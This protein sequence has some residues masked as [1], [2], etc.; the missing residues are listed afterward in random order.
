[1]AKKPQLS[2]NTNPLVENLETNCENT[3]QNCVPFTDPYNGMASSREL[4]IQIKHKDMTTTCL[5]SIT[6]A[7]L[8]NP[9]ICH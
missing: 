8:T 2:E 9:V 6:G 7:F 4:C 1:M 3:Y 5:Y